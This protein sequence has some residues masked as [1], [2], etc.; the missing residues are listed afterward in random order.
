M[1]TKSSRKTNKSSRKS[2]G[3]LAPTRRL[4]GGGISGLF[5][6]RA[7]IP[8]LK[9]FILSPGRDF[10]Q[11]ELAD[12]TGE[13]LLLVQRAVARLVQAGLVS[14]APRGN[15][16]YYRVD[17]SHPALQDL[18]AVILKTVGIGDALRIQL[19]RFGE[20]IKIA[21]VY[22]SVA[23]GEETASSDVDIMLIGNLSGREVASIFSP[24]KKMLKREINPTIYS[25]VEFRK[26]VKERHPFLISVLREPKLFL[27]GDGRA[28]KAVLNG[29][30]A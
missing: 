28:L 20:K 13:R 30:S 1:T 9:L 16:V 18:K 10:Y 12:L 17:E 6:G 4:R 24:V 21:F 29:R 19:A 22:G 27:L 14:Q 3:Q 5:A 11:R 8:L 25:P 15:R 2:R 7:I 26:R 23:R